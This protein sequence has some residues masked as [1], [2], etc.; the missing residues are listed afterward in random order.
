MHSVTHTL[1]AINIRSILI[2]ETVP[3]KYIYTV[4]S[5]LV[6]QELYVKPGVSYDEVLIRRVFAVT[7]FLDTECLLFYV[8]VDFSYYYCSCSFT[9]VR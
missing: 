1:Y 3:Y 7:S 8:M 9:L 2:L 6:T 4:C 5:M